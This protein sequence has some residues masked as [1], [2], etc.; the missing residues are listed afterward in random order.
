MMISEQIEAIEFRFE[1]REWSE[2]RDL[3]ESSDIVQ[4]TI[5]VLKRFPRF[6]LLHQEWDHFSSETPTRMEVYVTKSGDHITAKHGRRRPG[7]IRMLE[8]HG[9]DAEKADAEHC[10]CSIGKGADGKWYGWS[11]RAAVGFGLGDRVFE[12]GYGDDKTLFTKH[13]SKVIKTDSDARTA[14]VKFARY[15]S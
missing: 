4:R 2:V 8:K 13:G 14:A 5:K 7:L 12:E 6:D 9:I 3:L 10:V 15:V 1:L 11:H